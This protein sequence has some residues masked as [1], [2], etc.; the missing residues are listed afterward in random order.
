M[1]EADTTKPQLTSLTF[2]GTINVTNGD[3]SAIFTA[4][5]TDVGSGVDRIAIALDRSYQ[6]SFALTSYVWIDGA[7]DTF[8]DGSSSQA[9]LFKT[10]TAAGV[11]NI[12][13]VLVYDKAG[14][15]SVY[16]PAQLQAL[17]IATNFTV[18][19]TNVAGTAGVGFSAQTSAS[20]AEGDDAACPPSAPMAQI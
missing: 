14:N 2:P 18:A 8:A 9:N 10:T 16:S 11:Y 15:Y 5:A 17:G 6:A 20:F 4:G 7:T 3:V 1:A 19:D 13:N 12:Q